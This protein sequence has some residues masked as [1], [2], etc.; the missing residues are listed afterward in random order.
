MPAERMTVARLARELKAL[1]TRMEERFDRVD[2]RFDRVDARFEQVDTRFEQV[3]TRFEQV[4]ARFEQVDARLQQVDARLQQVDARFEQFDGRL[5]QVDAR[6]EQF[7]DRLQQ[8]DD[9]FERQR[10]DIHRDLEEFATR[11][12]TSFRISL[13]GMEAKLDAALDDT[14]EQKRRLDLIESTNAEEHRL[15]RAQIDDLESKLQ[16]R[17][18]SRRRPS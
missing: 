4:D 13:E 11:I 9:R 7:D 10:Q 5:Q 17:R 15:I 2:A 3:D 18:R 16:A 12:E 14:R 6:F 8:V 1:S